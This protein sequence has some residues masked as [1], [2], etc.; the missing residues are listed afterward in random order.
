MLLTTTVDRQGR[1][2]LPRQILDALGVQ[3]ETEI[4]IEITAAGALIKPHQTLTP[5][6]EKIAAMNLPVADWEQMEQEI[7]EGRVKS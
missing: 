3:S 1:V 6:T 4:V 7:V 2:K 5:I